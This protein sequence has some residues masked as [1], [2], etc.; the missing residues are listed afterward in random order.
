MCPYETMLR[1]YRETTGSLS[2][3]PTWPSSFSISIAPTCRDHDSVDP[4]LVAPR[5][6]AG[7]K[8]WPV[9]WRK[10]RETIALNNGERRFF[11][12][13]RAPQHGE[14]WKLFRASSETISDLWRGFPL[15]DGGATPAVVLLVDRFNYALP[16]S[17]WPSEFAG[18]EEM[19]AT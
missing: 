1:H 18:A 2:A 11:T 4:V 9:A 5:N 6:F 19:M 16:L 3:P 13:M 8:Q 7:A 10:P 15:G 12:P 17:T 14:R